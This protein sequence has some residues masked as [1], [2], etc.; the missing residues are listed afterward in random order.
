MIC[1]HLFQATTDTG[2]S[3]TLGHTGTSAAAPLAAGIIALALNAK[4]VDPIMWLR[5]SPIFYESLIPVLAWSV[6][7]NVPCRLTKLMLLCRALNEYSD[8][9]RKPPV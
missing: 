9:C 3:C 1:W 8:L 7:H 5:V 2:N 6:C 4:L